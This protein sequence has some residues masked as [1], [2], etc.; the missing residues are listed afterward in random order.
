[1]KFHL[2]IL[3]CFA[4]LFHFTEGFNPARCNAP[5]HLPGPACMAMFRRYTFNQAKGVCEQFIYGGCNPSPNNF[6]TMEECQA[7]CM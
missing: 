7:T 3:A 1:M 4:F 2:L 6:E 5:T